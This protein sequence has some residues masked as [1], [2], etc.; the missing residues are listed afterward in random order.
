MS[1]SAPIN[2]QSKLAE[3][4]AL[5]VNRRDVGNAILRWVIGLVVVSVVVIVVLVFIGPTIGGQITQLYLEPEY[6]PTAAYLLD[7]PLPTPQGFPVRLSVRYD[8]HGFKPDNVELFCV[9]GFLPHDVRVEFEFNHH[10]VLGSFS[11]ST[12]SLS[13]DEAGSADYC[14]EGAMETALHL[15]S[16]QMSSNSDMWPQSHYTYTW[17]VEITNDG[18]NYIRDYLLRNADN[19]SPTTKIL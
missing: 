13:N 6:I 11:R 1:H 9:Q 19:Q 10:L 3:I 18:Y 16:V 8:T 2:G 4:E 7:N 15:I 14:I 17:A 5:I 12:H